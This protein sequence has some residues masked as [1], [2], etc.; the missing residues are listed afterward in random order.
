VIAR[1]VSPNARIDAT[2]ASRRTRSANARASYSAWCL[3]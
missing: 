1:A 2:A 3:G